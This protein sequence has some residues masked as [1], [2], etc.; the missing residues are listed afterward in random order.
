MNGKQR[1]YLRSLAN[2]I[3]AKYQIGK[4]G[5]DYNFLDMIRDALEANMETL[6]DYVKEL[7]TGFFKRYFMM[8]VEI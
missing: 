6:L 5:I 3:E 2:S 4:N 1:A 8:K 7:K